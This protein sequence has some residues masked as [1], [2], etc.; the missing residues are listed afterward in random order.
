MTR[1]LPQ[2]L[3]QKVK[4]NAKYSGRGRSTKKQPVTQSPSPQKPVASTPSKNTQSK[5]ESQLES[6]KKL[7]KTTPSIERRPLTHGQSPDKQNMGS[8]ITGKGI[9]GKV[10]PT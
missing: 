2:Q 3:R 5:T 4:N 1:N 8:A 9:K 6:K 10:L 7:S